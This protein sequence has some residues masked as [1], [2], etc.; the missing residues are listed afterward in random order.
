MLEPPQGGWVKVRL[1][2]DGSV[3]YA[4][5]SYIRAIE[6]RPMASVQTNR[7]PPNPPSG[8]NQSS[9]IHLIIHRSISTNP[10]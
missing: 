3:G 1:E 4:P 2:R 9:K 6:L 7:V 5:E 10:S 8:K